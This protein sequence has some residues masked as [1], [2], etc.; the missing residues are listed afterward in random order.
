MSSNPESRTPSAHPICA[1]LLPQP[2]RP[3]FLRAQIRFVL[4]ATRAA[5]GAPDVLGRRQ[6]QESR[7]DDL[8]QGPPG[9]RRRIY[10]LACHVSGPRD[11]RQPTVRERMVPHLATT[12]D[13]L[14]ARSDSTKGTPRSAGRCTNRS[15]RSR[16]RSATPFSRSSS[17]GTAPGRATGSMIRV[18]PST[19]A[20]TPTSR[21]SSSAVMTTVRPRRADGSWPIEFRLLALPPDQALH[22]HI[23]D[24]A[25]VP[26]VR[27]SPAASRPGRHR[28]ADRAARPPAQTG[29]PT[30]SRSTTATSTSRAAWTVPVDGAAYRVARASL[31]GP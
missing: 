7:Q 18:G 20:P 5:P 8:R 2:N 16:S 29:S 11:H 12:S 15:G 6:K 10:L 3:R 14:N 22:G 24:S 31:L 9:L 17:T 30:T 4:P 28:C 26:R 13:V 27:Q 23:V 25:P 19:L 21:T 1:R